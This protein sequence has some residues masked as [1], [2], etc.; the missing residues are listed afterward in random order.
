MIGGIVGTDWLGYGWGIPH[1]DL[2]RE[3]PDTVVL[4]CMC[5]TL[6]KNNCIQYGYTSLC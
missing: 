4:L 5:G 6:S 2:K 1:V 3:T